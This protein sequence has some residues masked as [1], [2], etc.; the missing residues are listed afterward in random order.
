MK[1]S[2]RQFAESVR[3]LKGAIKNESLS[4]AFRQRSV[5]LLFAIYQ[6]PVVE[7]GDSHLI[8][9]SVKELIQTRSVDKV[10]RQ[11]VK[12][13]VAERERREAEEK[14]EQDRV[15]KEAATDEMLQNFLRPVSGPA[16]LQD[17]RQAADGQ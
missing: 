5:E 11:G 3:Y 4:Y 12:E 9:K 1:Y 17:E 14:A 6:M 8:K 7:A 15:Q 2:R 10:I 16:S 13:S